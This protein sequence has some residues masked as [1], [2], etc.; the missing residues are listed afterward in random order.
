MSASTTSDAPPALVVPIAPKTKTATETLA[1]LTLRKQIGEEKTCAKEK[2][3][4]DATQNG[5]DTTR[6]KIELRDLREEYEAIVRAIADPELVLGVW[7]EKDAALL[8]EFDAAITRQ[9]GVNDRIAAQTRAVEGKQKELADAT[10]ELARLKFT[11]GGQF[12]AQQR[13]AR[14]REQHPSGFTQ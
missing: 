11:S 12:A 13:L 6:L 7:N 2:V 4:T 1:A 14:H 3:L 5:E 10:S 8:A 9:Q